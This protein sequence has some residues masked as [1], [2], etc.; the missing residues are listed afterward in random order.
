M[1]NANQNTPQSSKKSFNINVSG[2]KFIQGLLMVLTIIVGLLGVGT[3]FMVLISE[4][5]S[6]ALVALII[7]AIIIMY[8]LVP[9]FVIQTVVDC[10][11]NVQEQSKILVAIN[12]KLK[13]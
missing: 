1:E 2:L 5:F 11:Y 9:Y 6:V 10:M 3:I 4:G 7:F 12:D 13:K 8:L